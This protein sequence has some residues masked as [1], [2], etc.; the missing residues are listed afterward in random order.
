MLSVRFTSLRERKKA[1]TKERLYVEALELFRRKG[2]AAST[3]ED[4]VAAADVSKGTFFNYFSGKEGL[5]HYVSE[6]LAHTAAEALAALP[7]AEALSAREQLARALQVLAA[8]LEADREL[9]RVVVF[10]LLRASAAGL[11]DPYRAWLSQTVSAALRAGQERGEVAAEFD[12]DLLSSVIIGAYFQ[13]VFEWCAAEQP[14]PLGERL[15]RLLA[16]LW[17][18]VGP[19]AAGAL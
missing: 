4:I 15:A 1:A 5:L 17:R 6:R 18:A 16:M 10:E 14:Y 13:Q 7:A 9:A 12:L 19:A 8:P 2:F 3:V 11:A